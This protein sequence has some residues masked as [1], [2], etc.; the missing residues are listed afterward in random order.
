MIFFHIT[1][2]CIIAFEI[3][4]A[5]NLKG[6]LQ[7]ILIISIKVTKVIFSKKISDSSK[8]RA[9]LLYSSFVFK[10]SFKIIL[11]LSCV[12]I[13][14]AIFASLFN[15]FLSYVK[16]IEGFIFIIAVLVLYVALRRKIN[17]NE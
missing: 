17:R 9:L 6:S 8:Q 2:F 12:L 7:E 5:G 15:G 10:Y 4:L 1:G 13:I 11:L 16:S 14:F 3:F